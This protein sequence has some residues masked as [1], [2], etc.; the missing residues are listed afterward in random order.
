MLKVKSAKRGGIGYEIGIR[1]GDEILSFDGYEAADIL[2]YLYYDDR[3]N[4]TVTVRQ[5]N[6][7]VSTAEIEKDD[8]ESLA[9]T[10]ESDNLDIMTCRNNCVFCFV[11]QMPEGMRESLYVKDD[12]YRQSFLCGN[13]VTLTNITE[14]DAE[15]IIRLN[16][17]PLYI[18]IHTMNGELRK[19]MLRN[20]FADK[21]IE[22]VKR[23]AKAGIEMNTQIVLVR[24]Y[25]DEKELEFSARELFKLYPFVKTMAVVPVG[26]TKYREGLTKLQNIDKNY[27]IS[28]L[29]QIKALNKEFGI[30]FIQPA[31]EFYFRAEMP[32]EPYAFYGSFPQIENG[33]GMTAKFI[34]ELKGSLRPAS[35]YSKLLVISGTSAGRFISDMAKLAAG[36]IEGLTV[37][38]LPIE[39]RF[40]GETV[41][42]TGLL[43]GKDIADA[44]NEY[45]KK[46]GYDFDYLVLPNN[47]LKTGT[48]LFLDDTTVSWLKEQIGKKIIIT[49]ASGSG[50]FKAL[51]G[52]GGING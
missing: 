32:V 17:S 21:T 36:Y 20:R 11:D 33:V 9:L 43:V 14:K 48:E 37:K 22:Y 49:D 51:S 15:R 6:G 52:K 35:F 13:F 41:N 4:F 26:L 44:V 29:T 34:K 27:A 18:S 16:L 45:V 23:F 39:N 7:D 50:F 25:N 47:T 24:G 46:T 1:K 31:D 19:K 2:D 28:V 40:F 8:D 42:C 38:T 12:D 10:F 30:N 3:E 5:T